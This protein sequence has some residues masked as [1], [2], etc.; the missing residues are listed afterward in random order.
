MAA[1]DKVDDEIVVTVGLFRSKPAGG[2]S[3]GEGPGLGRQ[4]LI[5]QGRG[6]TVPWAV[7]ELTRK[8]SRRVYWPQMQVIIIGE[9]LAYAGVD[10]ILDFWNKEIELRR[11]V[12]FLISKGKAWDIVK[13]AHKGL[14]STL[15]DEISG[16]MDTTK[17]GG[18]TLLS[19]IHDLQRFSQEGNG[20]ALTGMIELIVDEQPS[21]PRSPVPGDDGKPL[22]PVISEMLQI[23]GVSVLKNGTLERMIPISSITRGLLMVNNLVVSTIVNIECPCLDEQ[24]IKTG[25]SHFTAVKTTSSEARVRIEGSADEPYGVIYIKVKMN[26]SAQQCEADLTTKDKIRK[27]EERVAQTIEQEVME[28]IEEMKNVPCD[29]FGFANV[30]HI[31]HPKVWASVEDRWAN[32]FRTMPVYVE[33]KTHLLQV[34]MVKGYPGQSMKTR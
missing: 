20:T 30:F 18:Y 15:S 32:I 11:T 12:K 29:P 14:E 17:F 33:V 28:A 8:V 13:R 16:F 10:E 26:L 25:K 19:T 2:Q 21:I 6:E 34:G 24:A 1:F 23:T 7:R 5:A 4:G 31:R 22:E 27:T 3:E 9:D